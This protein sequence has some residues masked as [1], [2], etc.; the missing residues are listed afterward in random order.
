MMM[1]EDSSIRADQLATTEDAFLGGRLTVAQPRTGSRAGL[2]AIFLAAA[3]PA[4]PRQRILDAGSGSGIVSLALARRVEGAEVTGI[5]I[6][7]SLYALALSN[8]ARNGLSDRVRFVCGDLTGPVGRLFQA[9][10]APDSFDHAVANPPFLSEG[11]ARL[12]DGPMLRRAHSAMPGDLERWIKC[13]AALVK[14]RGSLTIVHR[15]EALPQLLKYC[16]RRFG[17]LVVY[18]L[19]PRAG[20]PACRILL[21]GRKASRT[22]FRLAPGMVLHGERNA[23]SQQAEAVLRDCAGLDLEPRK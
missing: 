12:P 15:T 7:P 3:C 1:A 4:K 14:P 17:D 19:F 23:F 5:E 21:R 6:D 11:E 16:D 9:G 2:D 8:A 22:P 18:P 20:A 13:L 10:L